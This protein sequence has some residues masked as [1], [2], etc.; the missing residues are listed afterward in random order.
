[1]SKASLLRERGSRDGGKVG[2][3]E[4]FFDLVFVFAVTQ[5]S[6]TLLER[7]T[8]AG[9]MQTL[10]LFLAVWW[11]W[12]YTSW[13]TN[14]LD[15]ARHPVR[16][17]LFALMLGG[18]LLSSS[19][20]HAFA[21]KGLVFGAVFAAMQVGRTLFF[22]IALHRHGSPRQF[23]NFLRVL[24]WLL[25]SAVFWVLGGLADGQAR[26]GW[27]LV[28]VSIEYVS[29]IIYFQVPG[30][31]RSSTADWDVDGAHMAERCMLFVIIALGESLLVTGATFSELAWNGQ[32]MAAFAVAFLGSVA[33]WWIYFDTGAERGSER[34][35]HSDD[36]GRIARVAY[37]YMH[38]PIVG[39]IIVCAVADELILGHP[40]H[41][42]DAGIAAIL[43]GPA[44]YL[45]GTALF[46]W[47]TNDRRG[48]PL[49]HLIGLWL[50]F[51]LTPFAFGHALSALQ[52]A[53]A[54]TAIL[55]LVAIW[56]SLALRRPA[57]PRAASG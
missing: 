29:P 22:V 41:V 53:A 39:G 54:T 37:T 27:W 46:K 33:M 14:F 15:P 26:V 32:T 52:L 3:I 10:L 1:M 18:L 19:I 31:G 8:P 49:S 44:L 7:L 34:I 20:P 17:L 11:L 50:L 55:L 5:L 13:F 28:A 57:K 47:V 43:G 25:A 9:A 23:R 51:V 35:V 6:H 2:M 48:P 45:L 16:L 24:V 40:E 38:I 12:I 4:L 36:P 30:L 21:D 42:A 56:E